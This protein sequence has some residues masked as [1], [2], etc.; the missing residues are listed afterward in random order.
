MGV[1]T[2][3]QLCFGI[4]FE[5]GY[6]FPWDDGRYE[7]DIDEWWRDVQGFEHALPYP[8]DE[9]GERLP[10]WTDELA[11]DY[12]QEQFDFDEKHPCPVKLINYC[13]N[14]SPMYIL[15]HTDLCYSNSRGYPEEINPA[16]LVFTAGQCDVLIAFCK[17]YNIDTDNEM[18]KW[19][20]SSYWG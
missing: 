5:D 16:Q 11:H 15:A 2:D 13:S 17:K 14:G 19:W 7:G 12:F 1:S 10:T 18:P 6:E 20:L 4:K 8:Y 9:K 3:G